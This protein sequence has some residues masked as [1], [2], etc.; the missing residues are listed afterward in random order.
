MLELIPPN[1][2]ALSAALFVAAARIFYQI[3]LGSINPTAVTTLVNII[4]FSMA[5][6]L[7]LYDGGVETWPYQGLLWFVSVGLTGSLFGRYMSFVSQRL[8]GVARMSVLM[9]SVLIWSTALAVIFLGERL[10]SGI[11]AGSLLIM[12]GGVFLVREK[13]EVSKKIPFLYYLAPLLTALSF[14]LTFLLRRY[15]L[16]WIPSSPLGMSVSN[17]TALVV[18]GVAFPFTGDRR[19]GSKK[20]GDG[21]KKNKKAYFAA[22][23]GGVFN[24]LAAIFFWTAVQMGE[25]VQVVPINRLSVL[26]VILF[27]WI[28]LRKQELITWRVVLGGVLSVAGAFILVA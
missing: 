3:A 24:A 10:S 28:F 14:A 9:Q 12:F 1:I 6:S 20:T 16:V 27:S 21:G 18:L 2:L 23:L 5:T 19:A 8:V 11:L 15:G 26:F 17:L 4:S 22:S 25:I 13:G 7:Y